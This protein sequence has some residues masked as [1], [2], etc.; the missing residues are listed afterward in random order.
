M[1]TSHNRFYLQHHCRKCG[2]V[3]CNDCTSKRWMLPCIS[4][5]PVRVC[6]ICFDSLASQSSELMLSKCCYCGCYFDNLKFF[7]QVHLEA[8]RKTIRNPPIQTTKPKRIPMQRP[9]RWAFNVSLFVFMNVN[10]CLHVIKTDPFLMF[11]LSADLLL[12][13]RHVKFP[14]QNCE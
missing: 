11:S 10:D 9:I 14:V 7:A 12:C 2:F 3:C 6:N 13:I 8:N 1:K 4:S 5:K